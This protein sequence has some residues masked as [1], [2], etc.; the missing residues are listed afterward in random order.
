MVC[1][2]F[3]KGFSCGGKLQDLRCFRDEYELAVTRNSNTKWSYNRT[4]IK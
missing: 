1:E 2:G 4:S 3:V